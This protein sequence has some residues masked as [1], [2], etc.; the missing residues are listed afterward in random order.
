M[1]G[2]C[3]RKLCPQDSFGYA[4]REKK[5]VRKSTPG[6]CKSGPWGVQNGLR[7][8]SGRLFCASCAQLR[9]QGRSEAVF[10]R[11]WGR[12]WG[13]LGA[14]LKP[15][16]PLLGR[17]GPLLGA[18]GGRFGTSQGLIWTFWTMSVALR[19]IQQK[20]YILQCFWASRACRR[21]PKTL[22]NWPGRPLGRLVGPKI[23]LEGPSGGTQ[24][25]S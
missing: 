7:E 13:A 9:R 18:L 4:F 2:V 19:E 1:L 5:T 15:L 20:P 14:V 25:P 23:G 6:G 16:G 17:P 11:L 22:Q 24:G 21:G 3:L 12:S 8:A 10:G